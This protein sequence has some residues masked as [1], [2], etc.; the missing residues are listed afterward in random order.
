MMMSSQARYRKLL[1][2]GE[3]LERIMRTALA[4]SPDSDSD[5]GLRRG[6]TRR[7][8]AKAMQADAAQP[9]TFDRGYALLNTTSCVN[10]KGPIYITQDPNSRRNLEWILYWEQMAPYRA[11]A[12]CQSR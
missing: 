4:R 2:N 5:R 3:L 11:Y 8:K 12:T 7:G 9:G 1:Y 6:R 10:V